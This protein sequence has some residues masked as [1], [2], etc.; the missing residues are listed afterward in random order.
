MAVLPWR[1]IHLFSIGLWS[2]TVA[3]FAPVGKSRNSYL[4][5]APSIEAL[6][7]LSS[8]ELRDQENGKESTGLLTVID[9]FIDDMKDVKSFEPA[10][11]AIDF[12]NISAPYMSRMDSESAFVEFTEDGLCVPAGPVG[13]FKERL[14]NI[15]GEPFVELIIAASVLINSLLVALSTLDVL[16]PY[17]NWIRSTELFVS[18]IFCLDFLGRWISSSKEYGKHVLDPQFALDVVVVILPLM[19]G[20]TSASFLSETPL[21]SGLTSPSGLF[22]LELLRVLRLRR[23]LRDLNTLERFLERALLGAVSERSVNLVQEWQLQLARVI[24]SLF[25][26]VSVSTGLIYTAENGVNPSINNYFDA[27]YFG[28]TT[29]TT[30]GFGDISPITWQGKLVVCGSILVGVAVVPAQAAALV[31]ALLE[32]EDIKRKSRKLSS[33]KMTTPPSPNGSTPNESSPNNI[34]ALDTGRACPECG[35]TCHWTNA[36][37]CYS[38]GEEMD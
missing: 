18:I 10:F 37:Y 7:S 15:L 27:L 36:Q 2:T 32:R 22:N 6:R 9:N 33:K 17:M 28:L 21:P 1:W 8:D 34:L 23:V 19:A 31:E 13:Q 38:C 25:T 14:A 4:V 11:C 12:D 29:L 30:V 26:L 5:S 20:I 35:A 3:G 24:L 16:E